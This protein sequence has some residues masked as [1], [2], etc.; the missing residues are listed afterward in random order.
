MPETVIRPFAPADQAAFRALVLAGL[1]DHFGELDPSLNHDLD[2]IAINYLAHGAVVIV[3]EQAGRIVGA[4]TLIP[5][6]PGVGRLA[7]MSV[8]REAR[9]QGLGARL[10][11]HLIEIARA[12][13]DHLL[14]VE[15]NDDWHD[16]IALYRACGFKDDHIANGEAHFHLDLDS[17]AQ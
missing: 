11:R 13:G 15:T 10:V 17:D 4:G 7:R 6:A 14:L 12:R 3:A 2:D 8:S 9:G 5:E 1:A 16:A